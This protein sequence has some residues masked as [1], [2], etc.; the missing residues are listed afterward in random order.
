MV[1]GRVVSFVGWGEVGEN[2]WVELVSGGCLV[3]FSFFL[4]RVLVPGFLC[5]FNIT[6]DK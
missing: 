3:Q 4:V 2:L 6:Y 1:I 5:R